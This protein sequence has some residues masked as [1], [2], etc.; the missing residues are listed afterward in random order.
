MQV[1]ELGEFGLIE[2][3][4]ARVAAAGGDQSSLLLGIGDDTAAWRGDGDLELCTTDTMVQGVHFSL[5]T[6]SWADVGWK[7]LAVSLSDIAA[8]GGEPRYAL[9]TLGLPEETSVASMDALYDGMLECCAEHG[10]TIVG[11]DIVRSPVAFVTVALTGSTPGPL[12]T[13]SAAR[14]GDQVAVTGKLGASG[15]WLAATQQVMSMEPADAEELRR[16][17]LRPRPRLKEGSALRTSEVRCAMDISDGL[18]ADLRHVCKASG[19]AAR[20]DAE[21]IP[22]HPA[23]LRAFP[24]RGL[25]LALAGGEE[26]ELLFTASP[27]VMGKLPGRLAGKTTIIGEVLGGPPGQ[28]TVQASTGEVALDPLGWDHFRS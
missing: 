26:Y 10:G 27:E 1:K 4:A 23:V 17:H 28:V 18:V 11:G 6:A 5:D 7:V 9:V 14:P 24:E 2:R 19:V 8:M 20:L 15:A 13:R 21:R 22:F 16:A 12:L 3:L 25:A